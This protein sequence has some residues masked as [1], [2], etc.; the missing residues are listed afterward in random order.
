MMKFKGKEMRELV[1]CEDCGKH[2]GYASS[3]TL[4]G[5]VINGKEYEREKSTY[6]GKKR[7]PDRKER[8]PGCGIVL[9][10]GNV[11][12]FGC[13]NERCP[14]CKGQLTSCDCEVTEVFR[15]KVLSE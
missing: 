3:C 6:F 11:H 2:R 13:D 9:R 8:C 7:Q 5:I 1:K 4:D 12:H 14:R 10:P 15:Q